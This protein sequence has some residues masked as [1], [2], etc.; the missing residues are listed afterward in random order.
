LRAGGRVTAYGIGI[1]LLL[2]VAKLQSGEV[3]RDRKSSWH[4][5]SALPAPVYSEQRGDAGGREDISQ[6][7]S[8][9]PGFERLLPRQG[10]SRLC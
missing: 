1:G 5:A 6:L 9:A 3:R 4:Y 10:A 2:V 7:H 8:A